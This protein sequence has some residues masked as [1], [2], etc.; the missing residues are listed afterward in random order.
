MPSIMGS[1]WSLM[2]P[3]QHLPASSSPS[4]WLLRIRPNRS[5]LHS[6]GN[7]FRF[8]AIMKCRHVRQEVAG[9]SDLSFT[10]D[11][12]NSSD[13]TLQLPSLL[14]VKSF[15]LI[16][17][18]LLGLPVTLVSSAQPALKL[19]SIT[20]HCQRKANHRSVG[21]S[22][23]GAFQ[24]EQSLT[25]SLQLI[26]PMRLYGKS[27]NLHSG[28]DNI[29]IKASYR[30]HA[31]SPLVSSACTSPLSSLSLCKLFLDPGTALCFAPRYVHL[32]PYTLLTAPGLKLA[33]WATAS[34]VQIHS[35]PP[36]C[37]ALDCGH[38]LKAIVGYRH[39][40][41]QKGPKR[42]AVVLCIWCVRWCS[43]VCGCVKVYVCLWHEL[44]ETAAGLGPSQGLCSGAVRKQACCETPQCPGGAVG[45][46]SCIR[47]STPGQ[48]TVH[49]QE[50]QSASREEIAT[51]EV[52]PLMPGFGNCLPCH[53]WC[54]IDCTLHETRSADDTVNC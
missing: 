53:L 6:A 28:T 10:Q 23:L 24:G 14:S 22:I 2:I 30:A 27:R 26:L 3:A 50:A 16:T 8:K 5:H 44:R 36:I 21:V 32:S 4:G 45:M 18:T 47:D 38:L 29:K 49:L 37:L 34:P 17:D 51:N 20:S 9:E 35:G 42:A 39:M 15:C 40:P 46:P 25:C 54:L 11:K 13:V 31:F 41:G 12:F 1:A 7:G 48:N 43:M 19:L 33:L 52:H